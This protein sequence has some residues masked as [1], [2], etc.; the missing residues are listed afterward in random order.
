MFCHGFKL[1]KEI[2]DYH[3]L[4]NL[5]APIT[6]L[7]TQEIPCLQAVVKESTR[8]FPSIIYQLLRYYYSPAGGFPVVEHF[9][10]PGTRV[11]ISPLAQNRDRAI[12]G[13]DADTFRPERWLG[14]PGRARYP[15][16]VNITFR[17]NGPRMRIGK[18]IALVGANYVL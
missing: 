2:D 14:D 9:I 5:T 15:N 10:P 1:Q 17:G 7:Q 13:E 18:N 16:S 4:S 6:Y 12:W 11:G 8:I 3:K